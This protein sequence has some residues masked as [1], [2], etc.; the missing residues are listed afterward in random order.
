MTRA[1]PQPV[2]NNDQVDPEV[3]RAAPTK[4]L[5]S[6][7]LWAAVNGGTWSEEDDGQSSTEE[8]SCQS[9]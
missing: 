6:S 3:P 7:A 8:E 5:D 9:R 1:P 2:T 4:P